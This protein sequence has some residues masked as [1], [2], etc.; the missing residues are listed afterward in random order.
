MMENKLEKKEL[1]I[2]RKAVDKAEDKA[3]KNF[4]NSQIIGE[5]INI[6]EEFIKKKK[7]ICYGG[8]AINNILPQK[9]QFYDY[10]LEMPDYDFFSD[11]ALND[12][13]EL[14][15]IYYK[16]GY[17]DVEAKAGVHQGTF[18]I[19]VNYIPVAD[20]TSLNKTIYKSIKK[21]SI[22]IKG[23]LYAPPNFL[24]MSMYLE[25]SRPAGDV[26]RW[27]KILKRLILLNKVYP[28]KG[29]NCKSQK[30]QREFEG[31]KENGKKLF[32]ILRDTFIDLGL[33]FFGGYANLLYS[34]YMPSFVSKSIKPIP[35]FDI[36]S[37]NPKITS[38]IV[39]E[40]LINNGFN[41]V[42][43][44]KAAGIGELIA[45]HYEVNVNGDTV[46]F[47]YEPLGCHSYNSIKINNKVI[48][49]ATI[50]TMLSFYLA[51][52]YADRLYYDE[53]RILCMAEQLFIVQQK[54]RLSQKGLLKRFSVNC[55][56]TQK[57]LTNIRA[58]KTNKFKELKIRKKTKKN[59]K[60]FEF[61]FLRYIPTNKIQKSKRKKIKSKNK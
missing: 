6:V 37:K 28:I 34:K 51:F 40:K 18:K 23:I 50:D 35:D 12:T 2:L 15:D 53:D 61:N 4:L 29:I 54:N 21:N 30:I 5:I 9:Y 45:P 58:E 46:A 13:K 10:T 1:N 55:F 16:A 47:I 7:L 59:I 25:L 43:I 17:E 44:F 27:E 24:R 3:N 57:T 26:S 36:L 33:I 20:I 56:G 42:K 52:L 19:F 48:K 49:V 41:N 11:N 8:T 32:V 38:N 22:N 14:A 31:S 39:K 60:E